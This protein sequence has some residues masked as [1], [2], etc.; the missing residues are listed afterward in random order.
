MGYGYINFHILRRAPLGRVEAI[1]F[2]GGYPV[3]WPFLRIASVPQ[4]NAEQTNNNRRRA[5]KQHGASNK[6]SQAVLVFVRMD[7]QTRRRETPRLL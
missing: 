1:G 7:E 5:N 6:C 2:G 4:R 3:E